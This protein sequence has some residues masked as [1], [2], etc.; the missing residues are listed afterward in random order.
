MTLN[1]YKWLA[2]TLLTLGATGCHF[3]GG[4]ATFPG[5]K[6][7]ILL[8]KTDRIGGDEP[9]ATTKLKEFEAEALWMFEQK[10]DVGYNRKADVE[11]V[12]KK[13]ALANEANAA[14]GDDENVD[15][16]LTDVMPAAYIVLFGM[17]GKSYVSVE[18]DIVRVNP[19]G[20]K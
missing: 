8:S 17:K 11:T 18:G 5:V 15:I 19:A 1:Q 3:K 10:K 13:N 9:L 2:V 6:N 20:G 7:P 12:T 14:I 4:V 16:R